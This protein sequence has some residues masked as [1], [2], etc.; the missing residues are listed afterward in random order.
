MKSIERPQK[1]LDHELLRAVHNRW[2]D[3]NEIPPKTVVLY[4]PDD[5]RECAICQNA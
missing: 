5:R 1:R 4:L 2:T 3:A